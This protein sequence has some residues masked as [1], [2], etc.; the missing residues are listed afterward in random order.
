MEVVYKSRM[1]RTDDIEI[2]RAAG[3]GDRRACQ[4]LVD[5]Y[6]QQLFALVRHTVPNAEDA[7]EVLQDALLRAF[8]SLEDY[9]PAR[10][11][12]Q[13]W[14]SRIAHNTALNYVRLHPS[15]PTVALD[16]PAAI[17]QSMAASE[18]T[19]AELDA[20]F[21]TGRPDRVESLTRALAMLTGEERSLLAMR[22]T[23]ERSVKEMAYI[24]DT[25]AGSLYSRLYRLRCK[26]YNLILNI[27]N[28]GQQ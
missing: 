28:Y 21:S 18:V 12:L 8:R 6:G 1:R 2:I 3:S 15:V 27:E 11:S 4:T 10:A 16:T 9:N 20:A 14:L 24:L 22:Y 23:E 7:E 17:R 26:L 25:D 5:R 13:T 19:E